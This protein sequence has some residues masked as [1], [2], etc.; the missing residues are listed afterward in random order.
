[1][2]RMFLF[3]FLSPPS[4]LAIF[5]LSNQPC[6]TA[7]STRLFVTLLLLPYLLSAFHTLSL[8]FFLLIPFDSPLPRANNCVVTSR[9]D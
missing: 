2:R 3:C 4:T 8:S 7:Q 6:P 1:M 5:P 9:R